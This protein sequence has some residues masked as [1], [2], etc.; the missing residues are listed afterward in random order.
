MHP[1]HAAEQFEALVADHYEPLF[2]F[3]MSLTR[4][5]SD[6]C[7]LT[8]HT[9]YIWATKGHQLRDKSKSKTWLFTTL[10][11]AFL[12]AQRKQ[13]IFAHN[14]LDSLP[15]SLMSVTAS[16]PDRSDCAQIL[17]AL[18]KVDE[19]YQAAVALFYL[20]DRSYKD[21]AEI[22]NVPI[23]TVKSRI[24]RGIQ[25]LRDLLLSSDTRPELAPAE[26][27]D[28]ALPRLTSN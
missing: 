18:A 4:S 27:E 13:N 3:A 6:A 28:L 2:R 5:E 15:E 8:Q 22:L 14:E 24:A 20:E 12:L 19:A 1:D 16:G 17:P 26:C 21:I 7:D 11:R 25:Q 10:H 23:G 9:F